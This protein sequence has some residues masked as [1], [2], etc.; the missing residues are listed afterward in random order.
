MTASHRAICTAFALALAPAAALAQGAD[1]RGKPVEI[2][3]GFAAGGGY[4]AYARAL[5]S[6]FGKHL[7]GAPTVL[8]RNMPG[9]GSLTVVNHIAG[10]APKTGQT[11]AIFDPT[12]MIAPL[13][14][15]ANANYDAT[16]LVWVGSMA[17]GYNVCV[18]WAQSDVSSWDDMFKPGKPIPM[19]ATGPSDARYQHTA[20]LRNLFGANMQIIPGYKG[21]SDVRIAM[22]RGEI[23]GNCGDSWPSLKSTA[24]DWV[25]DKKINV[26]TQ[27]SVSSHPE[28]KDIPTIIERAKNDNDRAALRLLL[29][30]Q[31]AGR[32]FIAPPGTPADLVKAL[33]AAFEASLKD[34]ELI[35]FADKMNLELSPVPGEQIEAVVG[36]LNRTPASAIESLKKAI[37]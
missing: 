1:Y 22:E 27:F 9:A 24:A 30:P 2:L 19:G 32:P 36:E 35:A 7:P 3:V 28:L 6:V 16:R 15:E 21:S 17:R 4:D 5:G 37:K 33:R 20:I 14:G 34:P 29:G 13:L 23:T 26:L 18:T 8:V 31:E 25:R 11:I 12:L 10:V